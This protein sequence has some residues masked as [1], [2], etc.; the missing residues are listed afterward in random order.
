MEKF[1]QFFSKLSKRERLIFYAT[2]LALFFGVMDRVVY[3]PVMDLF[4]ELDQQI[5]V[6]ENQL[7]KNMRFLAV[8]DAVQARYSNYAAYAVS[9]GFDEEEIAGLLNAIEGL[10]RDAGLSLVNMKPKPLVTTELGKLYPVEVDVETNMDQ[11]IKFIHGLYSS[12]Y[13]L[14]VKKMNL[15]P[16]GK[17]T[18]QI[19]GYLLIYKTVIR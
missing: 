6:Q 10:A 3:Q 13:I 9:S 19:K 14:G 2:G 1:K 11:L 16:K 12:K 18:D 4:L 8:R 5:L 7:R 15:S 17:K